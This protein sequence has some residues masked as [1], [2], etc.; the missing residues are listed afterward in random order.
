MFADDHEDEVDQPYDPETEEQTE[1]SRYDL[2][3]GNTRNNAADPRRNGD[4]SEDNAYDVRKTEVIAL[5]H[6]IH[7]L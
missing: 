6:G 1:Y 7:L 4:Y 5:S 2:T 3:V